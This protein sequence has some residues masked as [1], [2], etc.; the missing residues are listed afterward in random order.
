MGEAAE[1][2]GV[3]PAHELAARAHVVGVELTHHGAAV[4]VFAHLVHAYR[5]PQ[6]A[7]RERLARAP[8]PGLAALGGVDAEEADA[9]RLARRAHVHGVAVHDLHD[10]ALEEVGGRR[11]PRRP[12]GGS[13]A[14][15]R[16]QSVGEHHL[17][18]R[19]VERDADR[20]NKQVL[21]VR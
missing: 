3:S 13:A 15:A 21:E 14:A 10:A 1:H 20:P 5:L 8:R 17:E 2:P 4:A 19:G 6:R 9:A 7:L 16:R 18:A 11:P 12:A